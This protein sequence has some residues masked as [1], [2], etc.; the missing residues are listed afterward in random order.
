MRAICVRLAV[1]MVAMA[2]VAMAM[3]AVPAAAQG[4]Q[5]RGGAG[6]NQQMVQQRQNE[7]LFRDIA[8]SEAQKA[9]ID[10]IQT[11]S[12]EAMRTAMQGGG[13]RDPDTRERTMAMRQKQFSEIR[14]VLT[15]EQQPIFDRNV[16]AMPAMGGGRR[17]PGGR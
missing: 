16:A 12:R 5:G 15:A 10:S 13:M 11:A 14:A 2:M 8:L 7:M 9:T 17:P 1:T 3:V 4:G 6:D